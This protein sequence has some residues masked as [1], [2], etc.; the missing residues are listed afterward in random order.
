MCFMGASAALLSMT[1]IVSL[2]GVMLPYTSLG[3]L[4]GFLPLP[5]TYWPML[6]LVLYAYGRLAYWAKTYFVRR[7]GM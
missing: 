4:L 5:W 6:A 1:L 7:W 3:R 2:S